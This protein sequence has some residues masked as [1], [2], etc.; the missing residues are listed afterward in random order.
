M[1]RIQVLLS[2]MASDFIRKW[3]SV[4]CSVLSHSQSIWLH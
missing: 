1:R 3:H 2:I 4:T